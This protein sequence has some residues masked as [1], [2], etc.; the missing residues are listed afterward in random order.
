MRAQS[1]GGA[2][3]AGGGLL[4]RAGW[5]LLSSLLQQARRLLP[6]WYAAYSATVL[7]S[8]SQV[9]QAGCGSTSAGQLCTKCSLHA[10]LPACRE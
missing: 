7:F 6:W 2:G 8:L 5:A 3:G 4:A 1:P 9:R 10:C